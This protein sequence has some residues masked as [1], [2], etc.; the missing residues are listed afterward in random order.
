M[1]RTQA[2]AFLFT[3][4]TFN[5]T[6]ASIWEG[7]AETISFIPANIFTPT[8]QEND[9]AH[10]VVAGIFPS[11]CFTPGK[12]EQEVDHNRKIVYLKNFANYYPES[13]CVA[14]QVPFDQFVSLGQL[15]AGTYRV[16]LRTAEEK[17]V[18]YGQLLVNG[19]T[20]SLPAYVYPR[21]IGAKVNWD[22]DKNQATLTLVGEYNMACTEMKALSA[23]INHETD[24]IE[25]DS[26][27]KAS[28]SNCAKV[29]S[30]FERFSQKLVL[31]GVT[32]GNT[33][34]L[35]LKTDSGHFHKIFRL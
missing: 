34:L 19:E 33:Y 9:N 4:F 27:G 16:I 1:F 17:E 5:L 12:V 29:P 24:V 10:L 11:N 32:K 20:T 26:A 25:I 31:D 30:R 6:H 21:T 15:T 18:Q 35:H 22:N 3:F 13:T 23:K 2:V 28:I 7:P 8:L 14:Y